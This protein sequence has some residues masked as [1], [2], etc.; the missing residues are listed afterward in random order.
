MPPVALF[1][2]LRARERDFFIL[3]ACAVEFLRQPELIPDRMMQSLL[4]EDG[5]PGAG[6]LTVTGS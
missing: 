1:P 3:L 6:L 4:A 2:V 5:P